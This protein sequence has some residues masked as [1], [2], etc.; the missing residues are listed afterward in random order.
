M[1]VEPIGRT[2]FYFRV[3]GHGWVEPGVELCLMERTEP[4]WCVTAANHV[5]HHA[6]DDLEAAR[7]PQA[8]RIKSGGVRE[9]ITHR[10]GSGLVVKHHSASAGL[11]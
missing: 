4:R 2:G 11:P 8:G 3:L 9:A 10:H 5:M 1:G 7:F 6:K